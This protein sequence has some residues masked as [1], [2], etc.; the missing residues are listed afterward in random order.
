MKNSK[1]TRKNIDKPTTKKSPKPPPDNLTLTEKFVWAA[2]GDL[3]TVKEMVAQ[4]PHLLNATY[5]ESNL[6]TALGAAC[7]MKNTA[8]I[9]YLL[10]Q[11]VEMDIF[12]ACVLGK[13][14]E[15]ARMLEGDPQLIKAKNKHGHNHTL[16]KSA[17][18]HPALIALL[19][20]RGAK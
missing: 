20:S 9:E 6:E 4:H 17:E 3:K 14:D 5:N 8:I 11:G 19:K 7:Q 12:A 15:V 18:H 16:L 10:A 13:M 2:H 1:E